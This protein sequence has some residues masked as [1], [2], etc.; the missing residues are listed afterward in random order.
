MKSVL[1]YKTNFLNSSE[2]FIHRLI[3]NHK[4]YR[5]AALCYRELHFTDH[6]QVFEAPRAGIRKWI[7]L[8]AFRLNLSLPYYERIIREQKPDVVHAHFGYDGYKLLQICDKLNIPLVI[9]FYGSDVSR[10]PDELFWKKRYRRM[11]KS[12]ARFIAASDFM[13]DQLI[14]LGFPDSKIYLARFGLDLSKL[15]FKE[16]NPPT[17]RWMMVGRLV[18]KKGFEIALRAA[19]I[20]ADESE[21]FTLTIFGDG[22][23]MPKLRTVQKEL[24]LET[25]VCFKGFKPIDSILAAHKTHGLFIAPSIT[26]NDGDMEGLP[27]TILEAMAVGTPV[28]STNHAAIPEVIEHAKTGF[29]TAE[30]DI[31]EL[32]ATLRKILQGSYPLESIRNNARKTIENLHNVQKMVSDVENIYDKISS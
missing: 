8:A 12:R 15:S 13:K 7:N 6:V 23:L 24:K 3:S 16:V 32:A 22:P 26:A 10:L 20:L 21:D 25:R 14:D 9:S 5:P 1:H 29:L 19:K 4:R 30:R 27:N 28:V 31:N 11:A 17:N 2:T 18:E